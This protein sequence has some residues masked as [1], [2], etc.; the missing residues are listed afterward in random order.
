MARHP[1]VVFI[2]T[3][4]PQQCGIATFT[5]HLIDA[6][7]HDG[8]PK[9]VRVA[10]IVGEGDRAE[11]GDR[12]VHLIDNT[13]PAAYREAA[14]WV[15]LKDIDVVCLQHEFGLFAGECGRDVISFLKACHKPVVTT[16]HTVLPEPNPIQREILS[17]VGR[18]SRRIVAMAKVGIDL[19]ADRYGVSRA[20]MV[21][22]AHG[23]PQVAPVDRGAV[24]RRLGLR[25]RKVIVTFGLLSRGKGIEYMVEALPA[26]RRHHPDVLYLVIGRTHP[27]VLRAEGEAYRETLLRRSGD[28]GVTENIRFTNRFVSDDELLPY[29]QAS[30]VY[31]TPYLGRDQITSGTLSYAVAAGCAVVSTPYLYAEELL[32][33]GR[34]RLAEF[35]SGESLAGEINAILD[36]PA[37]RRRL[38]ARAYRYGRSMTWA[39]VAR[40]YHGLFTEVAQARGPAVRQPRT[41]ARRPPLLPSRADGP[42]S[43]PRV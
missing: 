42:A 21:F 1:R 36:S 20:K 37:L 18:Q 11:F 39:S 25:G 7:P 43:W 22:V 24:R 8:S 31:V 27:N 33:D 6:M 30:D 28:L 40:R 14:A 16:L 5:Q 32:A 2:S 26:I 17:A 34:G 13:R 10:A 23:V 35:R 3:Y 15:N 29:L 4:P 19:L 38:K 12:V 9:D 41:P